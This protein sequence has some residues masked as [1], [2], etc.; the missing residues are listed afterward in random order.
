MNPIKKIRH[1]FALIRRIKAINKETDSAFP[2]S[3]HIDTF[4]KFEGRNSSGRNV[5]IDHSEL[6]FGSFMQED[7][8]FVR[9]K[10]G[11]Y[12][13]IA[14]QVKV[15]GG[16]HPTRDFISTYPAFYRKGSASAGLNFREASV[17]E[18]YSFADPDHNYWVTIG[19]DVWIGYGAT[20]LNGC[21]I[22]D[23][24]I[25]A[26]GSVVVKDVPAYAIVGGV[27]AKLIRYRFDEATIEK[28]LKL[29]WWDW[30]PE[31]LKEN[32]ADFSSPEAMAKWIK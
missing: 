20:L 8:S 18:D 14:G 28:L 27:P 32:V 3:A 9:S 24:A 13:S 25:V 4:S 6:G 10:I 17:F 5:V 2:L 26:A 23:G 16:N 15:V 31:K 19:N 1:K 30:A 22:G 11:K 7:C 21:K 29:R 12:C